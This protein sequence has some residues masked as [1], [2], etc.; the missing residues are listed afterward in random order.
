MTMAA[1]AASE[2]AGTEPVLGESTSTNAC[3]AA[4]D[5]KSSDDAGATSQGKKKA[6][7]ITVGASGGERRWWLVRPHHAR[8]AVL[9]TAPAGAGEAATVAAVAYSAVP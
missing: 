9:P 5:A 2:S 1:V 3:P 7:A 6:V 8:A 4:R